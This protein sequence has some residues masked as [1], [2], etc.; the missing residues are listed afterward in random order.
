MIGHCAEMA[1]AQTEQD[2]TLQDQNSH[3]TNIGRMIEDME[4]K[5]RNLLQEV[6]LHC[7][8]KWALLST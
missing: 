2:H 5:M 6:C 1:S 8:G 7:I 3:I 4:I